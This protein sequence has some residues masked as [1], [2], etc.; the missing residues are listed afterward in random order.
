MENRGKSWSKEQDNLV[1]SLVKRGYS[2]SSI[3]KIMRRTEGGIRGRVAKLGLNKKEDRIYNNEQKKKLHKKRFRK[4]YTWEIKNRIMM[5]IM[6]VEDIK[7]SKLA[8]EINVDPRSVQRWIYE[9]AMPSKENI[10]KIE[11]I[12]GIPKEILFYEI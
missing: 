2:Y 1:I 8:E 10:K 12:L 3:S 4:P 5:G 6:Y 9:G 11:K 7:V